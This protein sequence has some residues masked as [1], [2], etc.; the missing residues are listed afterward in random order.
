MKSNQPRQL[1]FLTSMFYVW[2]YFIVYN[3]AFLPEKIKS[4]WEV[5]TAIKFIMVQF[6][7]DFL[8]WQMLKNTAK[9]LSR[10]LYPFSG[11]SIG[12][13]ILKFHNNFLNLGFVNWN[14]NKFQGTIFEFIKK[15]IYEKQI[16]RNVCLCNLC[17]WLLLGWS[18]LLCTYIP[19]V[20]DYKIKITAAYRYVAV[21]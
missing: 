17:I 4:T 8:T 19:D 10:R 12:I 16:K 15:W 18:Q 1:P 6:C 2:R 14:R 3:L 20:A 7:I 9:T 5:L 21:F 13:I 11:K